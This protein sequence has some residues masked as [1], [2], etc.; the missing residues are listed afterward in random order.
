MLPEEAALAYNELRAKRYFPVH[1]G[2]FKVEILIGEV[3]A[4][5]VLFC[6]SIFVS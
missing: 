1:W 5:I 4:L 3:G 6:V 2:M